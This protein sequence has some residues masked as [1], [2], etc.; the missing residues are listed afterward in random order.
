MIVIMCLGGSPSRSFE[1]RADPRK[2]GSKAG[3]L[4]YEFPSNSA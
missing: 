2:S 1:I 4:A 3:Q